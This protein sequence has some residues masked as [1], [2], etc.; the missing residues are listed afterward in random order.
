[1]GEQKNLLLAI[2]AS[3]VVLLGFQ[4]LFPAEKIPQNNTV[5]ESESSFTPS[6][7]V[8]TEMPKARN[9]II[10]ESERIKINNQYINGSITLT[11]ARF[12][13]IILTNYLTDLSPNSENVKYLSPKGSNDAY[14]AEY[15][16]SLIHI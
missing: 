12:D 1:M 9:E 10:N 8:I 15:G 2:L 3:L 6:P 11:G 16:L 5:Q 4:L 14:F 13:D 7:E